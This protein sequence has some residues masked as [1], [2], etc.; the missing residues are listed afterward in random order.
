M[1]QVHHR[2]REALELRP[3]VARLEQDHSM[4]AHL[5]GGLEAAMSS[6]VGREEALRH[7]EGVGAIMEN[8]FRYE[9]REILH[10]LDDLDDLDLAPVDVLGP[11]A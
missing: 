2:L 10:L 7:L 3:V 9:E 6:G 8:H 1:Q 11:L 4:I 5:L